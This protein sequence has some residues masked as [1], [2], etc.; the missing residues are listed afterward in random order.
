MIIKKKQIIIFLVSCLI[1]SS[2]RIVNANPH[3]ITNIT[4]D[5]NVDHTAINQ[6]YKESSK[7][8][9]L[10]HEFADEFKSIGS[11]PYI[12]LK[13]GEIFTVTSGQNAS[14]SKDEGK[15]WNNYPIVDKENFIISSPVFI[16]TRNGVIIMAFMNFKEKYWDWDKK[17][18]DAPHAVL[19]TYTI[20]SLDGGKTWQGVQKLHDDWTGA[21]RSIIE[22]RKGEVIFSSMMLKHN[23]AHH[24]VLTYTSKDNGLSW[25]R[26]NILEMGGSGDHSG[27][28]ESTLLELNDGRIWQLIRTNWGYFYESFS[29]NGGKNWSKPRKTSI[30]ASSS[31]AALSR[32]KSG[33][34]LLVWNRMYQEGQNSIPLLGGEQN[35]NLSEVAASWQR[36]E[37]AIAFSDNDGK[38]WT[39]PVVIAKTNKDSLYKYNPWDSKKR[40]AYPHI[41]ELDSGKIRITTDFGGLHIEINES[42]F[43]NLSN[44]DFFIR[45]NR[46]VFHESFSRNDGVKWSKPQKTIIDASSSPAALARPSSGRLVIVR[47]RRSPL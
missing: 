13:N 34:L 3:R 23:P 16:E 8:N 29:K 35:P 6:K 19:P 39:Q 28:M 14:I 45:T 25:I 12:R 36:E 10:I 44:G 42:D 46:G 1:I 41:S 5:L 40:L 20:R 18:I 21:I 43:V 7:S 26:S 31:P 2:Q 17:I 33:R 37:L 27:L 15:T 4:N 38:N 9:F 30:D 11:V 24:T 22:T 32:L 47:N